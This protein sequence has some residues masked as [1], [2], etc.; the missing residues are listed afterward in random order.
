MCSF[1]QDLPSELFVSI[2]VMHNVHD[3]RKPRWKQLT[4]HE[5]LIFLWNLRL[6]SD[7]FLLN[8]SHLIIKLQ[9]SNLSR[10]FLAQLYPCRL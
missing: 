9:N 8:V 7:K 6:P 1:K 10:N 2:H 4:V 3:D 5:T